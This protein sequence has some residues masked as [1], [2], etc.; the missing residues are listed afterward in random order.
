MADRTRR[1]ILL[2]IPVVAILAGAGY[3]VTSANRPP[4][5]DHLALSSEEL[6]DGDALVVDIRHPEEWVETGVV[7]GSVL[8]TYAGADRFLAQVGPAIADGRDLVLICRS[9]NR[10]SRA[11]AE[12][13]DKIPNRIISVE[14]G[15]KRIIS[16]GYQTVK[17]R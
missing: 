1:T 12:L 16:D 7:E 5:F 11:A 4:A 15:I 8:F 14:G 13:A 2:A 17:P 6:T 10:T 9:G 3:T